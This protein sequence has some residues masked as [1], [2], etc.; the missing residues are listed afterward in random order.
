M[1]Q[2]VHHAGVLTDEH[3][4]LVAHHA[5]DDGFCG[6]SGRRGGELVRLLITEAGDHHAGVLR[7]VGGNG[8]REH[9]RDMDVGSDHLGVETLG[10]QL[11]GR[12][13]GAVHGLARHR[14]EAAH[15]GDVDDVRLR[16]CE[17][18]GKERLDHVNLSVQVDIHDPLDGIEL[19]VLD[20]HK[21]LND[22]GAVDEAIHTSCAAM[23]VSGSA[24]TAS[25]SVT[26]TTCRL[27]ALLCGPARP[28]VS[29][30]AF[31]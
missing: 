21:G 6:H 17:Q 20:S 16:A 9:H 28:C 23:T 3:L 19:Q 12:L 4:E 14:E 10:Q 1:T 31:S 27:M 8:A 13:R 25:R 18:V 22:A 5:V 15:A 29:C 7:N 26:L 11:H 24:L 2:Q 30:R